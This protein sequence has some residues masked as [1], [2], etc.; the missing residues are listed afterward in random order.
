MS[1]RLREA[2]T[3]LRVRGG[4]ATSVLGGLVVAL[5]YPLRHPP[6]PPPHRKSRSGLRRPPATPCATTAATSSPPGCAYSRRRARTGRVAVPQAS[7][8]S[9]T[10]V[11]ERSHSCGSDVRE[12]GCPFELCRAHAARFAQARAARCGLRRARGAAH[13]HV[14]CNGLLRTSCAC[15][16]H[17]A[18]APPRA[19][20]ACS[21]RRCPADI[22]EILILRLLAPLSNMIPFVR[23][24]QPLMAVVPMRIGEAIAQHSDDAWNQS[25][26]P[27]DVGVLPSVWSPFVWSTIEDLRCIMASGGLSTDDISFSQT[28]VLMEVQYAMVVSFNIVQ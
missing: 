20:A 3:G 12:H 16:I 27:L 5:L 11:K 2:V 15:M 24:R 21:V 17:F 9:R 7:R 10:V 4:Y 8:R 22:N 19:T 14:E 13:G 23:R 25:L 6:G 28:V 1:L 26:I 18:R